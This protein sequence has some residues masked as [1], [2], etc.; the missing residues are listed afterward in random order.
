VFKNLDVFLRATMGPRHAASAI[1]A[2]MRVPLR[3]GHEATLD[4][5]RGVCILLVILGHSVPGLILLGTAGVEF[6]FVLSG[7][8]MADILV[9]KRQ[10]IG[11]FIKRRVARVVPA[12][13]AYVLIAGAIINVSI[14]ATGGAPLL[15]S[16]AAA[17]LFVHNY[18]PVNQIASV[19]EHTWSLAVEEHSYLVLIAISLMCGRRPRL[20]IVAA[21]AVCTVALLNGILLGAPEAGSQFVTWRSDFRIFSVVLS[22]ATFI[23]VRQAAAR[24]GPLRLCWIS[25]LAAALA[26]F[27]IMLLD[28]A[29]PAQLVVGT[30]LAAL[31]VNT[32]ETSPGWMRRLLQQP[33]LIW[34]G[35]I[36]F[37]L[38][39]WQQLYFSLA[40][41]GL[42]I[43]IALAA[44]VVSALW[45]FKC[46]ENPSRDY[47][48]ERWSRA[49]ID[50]RAPA[51]VVRT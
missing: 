50:Q 17:L 23:L 19:F 42:P 44:S 14:I 20:A 46:I 51:A 39:L 15:A 35:T 22:F 7:R 30:C 2:T 29:E 38:Y 5:W 34:A 10:P 33:F 24:F 48:N 6:F 49:R 40:H 43:A 8:L 32:L 27:A 37:S 28:P 13:A 41:L 45:S 3:H 11:M 4:G 16:P 47:L 12:L 26:V 1:L 18:L 31:A 36:S 25:P 21:L 9:F